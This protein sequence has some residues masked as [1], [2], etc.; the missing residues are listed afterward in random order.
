MTTA[1]ERF[2]AEVQTGLSI[3]VIGPNLE[4]WS[5]LIEVLRATS[6]KKLQRFPCYLGNEEDSQDLLDSGFDAVFVDLD[7]NPDLA[8]SMVEELCAMGPLP[9]I[10]YSETKDPELL[11]H[12]MRAGVREFLAVP[13]D[14]RTVSGALSRAVA[15]QSPSPPKKKINCEMFAFFGSKGGAGVTTIACN[16]AVSLAQDRTK[17]TLL[18]D[19]DLPLGDAALV[20]GLNPRLSTVDALRNADQLSQHA[21]ARFLTRHDSGLWVLGAPGSF[22]HVKFESQSID[23]LLS[24]ARLDFDYVIVDAGSQL[25][26]T[27]VALFERAAKLFMVTEVGVPELRN[28]NRLVTACPSQWLSKLEIVLNRYSTRT[29]GIG[30]AAIEKALT[31]R[32]RWRIPSDYHAVQRSHRNS[33]ALVLEESPISE[34]ICQMATASAGAIAVAETPKNK[35]ADLF[36]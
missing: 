23:Q 6:A 8:L 36:R 7:S 20:L 12:C 28:S 1:V 13:F 27:E 21:L 34:V 31:K 35:L 4:H 9:V 26:L 15:R 18:I 32:P 22:P 19:L 17:R 11:V 25:D 5:M 3:A 30:E 24:V 2:D 16:F 14:A 29:L 10:I 33:S